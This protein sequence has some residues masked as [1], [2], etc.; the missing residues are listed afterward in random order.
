MVR[1]HCSDLDEERLWEVM[2]AMGLHDEV[3]LRFAWVVLLAVYD[4]YLSPLWPLQV[5]LASCPSEADAVLAICSR[6]KTNAC[7]SLISLQQL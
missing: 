4:M 7:T 1:L 5:H 6:L 2:S 3:I